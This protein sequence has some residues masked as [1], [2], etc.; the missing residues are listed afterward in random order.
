MTHPLDLGFSWGKKGGRIFW[1]PDAGRM[2]ILA[3]DLRT[4]EKF[5]ICRSFKNGEMQGSEKI[6]GA[7]S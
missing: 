5:K 4:V 6:Q 3:T 2:D 1:W 7:Q